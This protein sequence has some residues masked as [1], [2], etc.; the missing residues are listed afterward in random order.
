MNLFFKPH[1]NFD[2]FYFREQEHAIDYINVESPADNNK[3]VLLVD[4]YPDI[5]ITIYGNKDNS[6]IAETVTAQII[7]LLENEKYAIAQNGIS[8][9]IRPSDLG[10][11]QNEVFLL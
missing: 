1:H 6:E 4:G 11:W 3:G 10:A 5:P 8:R 2:T 7:Q 9:R